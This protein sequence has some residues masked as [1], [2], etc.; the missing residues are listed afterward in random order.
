MKKKMVALLAGAMLMMATSAMAT[1][2][3]ANTLSLTALQNYFTSWGTQINANTEEAKA[4]VFSMGSRSGNVDLLATITSAATGEFG[5]YDI[6]NTATK[7]TLFSSRSLATN[8]TIKINFTGNIFRTLDVN[9]ALIDTA[10]FASSSF[11][12][13]E[14]NATGQTTYSQSALNTVDSF[15]TYRSKNVS[16]TLPGY[17]GTSVPD[18]GHWYIAAEDGISTAADYSDWVIRLESAQPVPEPG[19]MM[20]LGLGMLGMAV[21]GKRRQNKEA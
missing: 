18:L 3:D 13:Y 20:L 7:L 21:Y 8:S 11:G 19:T 9:D 10:T 4:E 5:I 17:N 16:V 1:P 14:T 6:S 15:L 12:F 2:I